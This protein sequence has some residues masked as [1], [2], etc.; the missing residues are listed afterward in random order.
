M[1]TQVTTPLTWQPTCHPTLHQGRGIFRFAWR[2]RQN[3]TTIVLRL[4]TVYMHLPQPVASCLR[5][6]REDTKLS[7]LSS[8]AFPAAA[9]CPLHC[10][11]ARWKVEYPLPLP[12]P[13]G[14][15]YMARLRLG[16]RLMAVCAQLRI[17]SQL[18]EHAQIPEP[19]THGPSPDPGRWR[20]CGELKSRT[21]C[22]LLSAA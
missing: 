18:L 2:V 12:S 3:S 7:T 5:S 15:W 14:E 13:F 8:A 16:P 21:R 17:S 6:P 11:H 10:I 20:V 9:P 19:H 1:I 22:A 4:R